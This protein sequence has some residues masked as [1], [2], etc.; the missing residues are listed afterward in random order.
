M[1]E[2]HPSV[3][4]QQGTEDFN[5][6]R[7]I[8]GRAACRKLATT[9]Y[10]RV[11]R[12]PV[13][14]PLF[15]GKTFTCAIEEFAAFLA[16][17]LGGPSQDAKRRW[18]LSLYES[19]LRFKISENEREAWMNTMVAAL[20]DMQFDPPIC[21]ALQSFFE[22]SSTYLVNQGPAQSGS[23]QKD[24]LDHCIHREISWRWEAQRD[25]DET[26]AAIR[27]LRADRAIA[28]CESAG[29][30]ARFTAD[31]SVFAALLAQMIKSANAVLI[32]Y[33]QKRLQDDP[34]LAREQYGGRT[35][36]HDACGVGNLATV[37]LLLR[38]DADPN[39][40]DHSPL[41]C[42][43]NE[44]S[45]PEGADVVR[46]LVKRGANVNMP[47][48]VKRCTALHMAARRGNVMVTV[49]LLDCGAEIE[50]RDTLG[51]TA[52]RRSVN[53]NHPQVA[54]LLVSRGA[55]V[56]SKGNKGLTPLSAARTTEMS[57]VLRSGG[58]R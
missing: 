38:L 35:L 24:C 49:A 53:C 5:L 19:H 45:L 58:H 34:S 43:A 51:D 22:Q 31:R 47:N 41:Y 36:L 29:L 46:A 33:A 17:F 26:V 6:Y 16:Q 7:A 48:G 39:A 44:C 57:R 14:R 3:T 15:P 55:D 50:A 30:R 20:E 40:G 8:G 9:F 28:Q 37:A 21:S 42:L 18:W 12:H 52:L 27:N 1:A 4:A 13:L 11:E 10:A 56:D 23:D 25:L 32:G 54:T 2:P